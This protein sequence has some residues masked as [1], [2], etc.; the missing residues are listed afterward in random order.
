MDEDTDVLAERVRRESA[1][2]TG[3]DGDLVRIRN[4]TKVFKTKQNPRFVAVNG[5]NFGLN[6]GECFG[7]L[8]V[9]GLSRRDVTLH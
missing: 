6:K 9:N 1:I 7:L 4:L 2:S 5:L 3:I 8:G